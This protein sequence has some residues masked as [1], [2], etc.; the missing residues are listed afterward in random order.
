MHL[1]PG[2]SAW[3]EELAAGPI[4]G[5]RLHAY[6]GAMYLLKRRLH[7]RCSG[8]WRIFSGIICDNLR[9]QRQTPASCLL[10]RYAV[11]CTPHWGGRT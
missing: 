7:D 1:L 4:A 5:K 9:A 2:G 6:G 11:W 8:G 3:T 10:E